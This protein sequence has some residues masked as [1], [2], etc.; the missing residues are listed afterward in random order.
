MEMFKE[1]LT[2]LNN[3]KWLAD[4]LTFPKSIWVLHTEERRILHEYGRAAKA[5]TKQLQV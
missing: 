3:P 4:G 2:N 5:V 1:N